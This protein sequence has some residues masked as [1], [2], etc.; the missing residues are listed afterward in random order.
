MPRVRDL[1]LTGTT[2]AR[3]GRCEAFDDT[4]S[5]SAGC[6]RLTFQAAD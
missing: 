6:F 2:P 1:L 5:Q 4:A 3:I